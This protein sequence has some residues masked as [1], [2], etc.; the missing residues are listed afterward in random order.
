ME[1]FGVISTQSDMKPKAQSHRTR[2]RQREND[3]EVLREQDPGE[4]DKTL[5]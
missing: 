4:R 5:R 3:V 1:M 2:G